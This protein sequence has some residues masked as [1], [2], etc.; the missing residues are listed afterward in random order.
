MNTNK[1]ET[2]RR[3]TYLTFRGLLQLPF[4]QRRDVMISKAPM[5]FRITSKLTAGI[6]AATFVAAPNY[7]VA[8]PDKKNICR[9]TGQPCFLGIDPDIYH[10]P[11]N[12]ELIQSGN[13]QICATRSG[14]LPLPP[15]AFGIDLMRAFWPSLSANDQARVEGTAYVFITTHWGPPAAPPSQLSEVATPADFPDEVFR[16]LQSRTARIEFEV[17]KS[18]FEKLGWQPASVPGSIPPDPNPNVPVKLRGWYIRGDGLSKGEADDDSRGQRNKQS[19]TRPL[20]IMSSGFPY[21]IAYRNLVGGI[22]VGRQMRKTITYLVASGYD[23]LFFDKRGHGY[24]EGV[25][26]GMG[27]DVF[28]ALDQLDRGVITEDGVPLSLKIITADG[29]T[30]QGPAAAAERL[31]GVGYTAK[32]K[33]VVLRGFSYGSSQMQKAMAMNYSALPV[34]YRFKRDSSGNIVVDLARTP[35]G[36]RGY[37]FRG[38]VAISGF[39]GS[40]KY[41]TVPFFLALDSGASVIGHSGATLKS[42]VYQSM[43]NW[44]AFLGLY[45]TNDF[46]TADGAIDAYNNKL[47]GFKSIE[48][49]TGYHFGLASE[50]VDTY[51]AAESE[52]FA[53]QT[54]FETAPVGN[55]KTTTYAEEVC[56]AEEV[57]IDPNTQSILDVPSKRIRHAIREVDAVIQHWMS[58]N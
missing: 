54:V 28:R 40:V 55:R 27:E 56:A 30:L 26:D 21:S 7:A 16:S 5:A 57:V 15:E 1:D 50:E 45:A 44:P 25:L 14:S 3:R 13:H 46:E 18:D 6:L 53:R 32:T 2:P 10:M 51:F 34:E 49:V 29:R 22:D 19:K 42:T 41:E 9:A 36:P 37:N 38:I 8:D 47:N 31:L 39:T 20:I 12:G 48:M 4:L 33:P 52:R 17:P 43:E 35:A 23:V 11:L 58:A 24:S